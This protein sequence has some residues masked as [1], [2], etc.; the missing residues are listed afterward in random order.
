MLAALVV[1]PRSLERFEM[2]EVDV[3]LAPGEPRTGG[4]YTLIR[5]HKL[6]AEPAEH[7][8]ISYERETSA[9][10]ANSAV[11][12]IQRRHSNRAHRVRVSASAWTLAF[13]AVLI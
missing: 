9:S 2:D 6:T 13:C 1:V 8:E 11:V 12:L 4:T 7:A 10:S 5:D 3:G